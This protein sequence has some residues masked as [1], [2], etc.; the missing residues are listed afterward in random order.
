MRDVAGKKKRTG[1][2]KGDGKGLRTEGRQRK[3]GRMKCGN[4]GVMD[5]WKEEGKIE[6]EGE[7]IEGKMRKRE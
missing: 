6:M 3:G 4:L 5:G 2:E 7:G 1:R